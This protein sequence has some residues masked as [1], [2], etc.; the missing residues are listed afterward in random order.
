MMQAQLAAEVG[1]DRSVASKWEN[2]KTDNLPSPPHHKQIIEI[3]RENGI[4]E[5]RLL[6]LDSAWRKTR[7]AY[8][9]AGRSAEEP[10]ARE[11]EEVLTEWDIEAFDRVGLVHEL[12]AILDNWKDYQIAISQLR[13][14]MYSF[15]RERL[16]VL[17]EKLL[18]Q[19][20]PQAH[21]QMRVLLGLG[22]ARRILGEESGA[23]DTQL[24]Q[25]LSLA[26]ELGESE[27]ERNSY[28]LTAIGDVHR[29][30]GQIDES[31]DKYR[32]AG[33]SYNGITEDDSTRNLGLAI[34]ERKIGGS[35]LYQGKASEALPHIS[36]SLGVLRKYDKLDGRRKTEQHLAWAYALVGKFEDAISIHESVLKETES[37]SLSLVESAKAKR[38]T[39]DVLRMAGRL[40]DAEKM[41]DNAL[42][43]L[44]AFTALST[45]EESLVRGPIVL[46]LGQ[47]LRRKGELPG[48]SDYLNQSEMANARDPFYLG[49]TSIAIGR[50]KV[51]Q[52]EFP[53]AV[54]RFASA[55]TIFTDLGN[56]YYLLAIDLNRAALDL[57]RGNDSEAGKIVD[58]II[59]TS[60]HQPDRR[61]HVL[62]ALILR[63]E[64]RF[65]SRLIVDGLDDIQAALQLALK[66][67][68]DP[69]SLQE[70]AGHIQRRISQCKKEGQSTDLSTVSDRIED[71]S[72]TLHARK[73]KLQAVFATLLAQLKKECGAPRRTRKKS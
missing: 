24:R 20:I 56:S 70:V 3:L 26:G 21:L 57:S 23:L 10:L 42:G 52:G 9:R 29:R 54:R 28:I 71:W 43:D 65:R 50:L 41:Y 33:I 69:Y 73:P 19:N 53:E 5:G 38:F 59:A 1:I 6:E 49:R 2:P 4:T 31:L 58:E 16:D 55:E 11:L 7:D 63:S 14:G 32:E 22:T 8:D 40:D 72:R 13:G 25:A 51:D 60:N 45:D 62:R 67:S 15:A 36:S 48:A 30:L 66:E 46:G 39:A 17:L 18:H 68:E 34:V 12:R 37:S 35:L 44:N 27:R 64:L 61:N 47:T